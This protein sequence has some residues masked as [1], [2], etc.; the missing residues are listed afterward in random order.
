VPAKPNTVKTEQVL[1]IK[2]VYR[3]SEFTCTANNELGSTERTVNVIITGVYVLPSLYKHL[4][5]PNRPRITADTSWYG[6]KSLIDINTM[7]RT[8]NHKSSCHI[9]YHLLYNEYID[10]GKKLEKTYRAR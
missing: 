6:C 10:S 4:Y 7:A 9:L 1:I 3:N 8:E 5:F 2:E